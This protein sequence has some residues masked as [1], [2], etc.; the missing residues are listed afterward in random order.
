MQYNEPPTTANPSTHMESLMNRFMGQN[1]M[2]TELVD[3]LERIGHR[4]ND[5]NVP[6]NE[7]D[8]PIEKK[9]SQDPFNNGMLMTFKSELDYNERLI[10]KLRTIQLKFSE[11]L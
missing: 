9:G 7:N 10:N 3:T 2:L 6:R 11:S 5:T 1:K 8:S 4:V